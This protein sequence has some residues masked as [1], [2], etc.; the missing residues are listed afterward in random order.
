MDKK[1]NDTSNVPA[2]GG[3]DFRG[4]SGTPQDTNLDRFI[5]LKFGK[6]M[7]QVYMI[8]IYIRVVYNF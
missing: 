1:L 2:G 5:V 7:K 4:G 6:I 3:V 8:E